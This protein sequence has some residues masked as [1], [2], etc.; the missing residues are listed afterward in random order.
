MPN[1]FAEINRVCI[2]VI[3]PPDWVTCF[4]GGYSP[5]IPAK[6]APCHDTGAI[7]QTESRKLIAASNL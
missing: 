6:P 4:G 1:L 5:V 7:S 2:I 3:D